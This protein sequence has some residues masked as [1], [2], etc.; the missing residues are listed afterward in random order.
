VVQVVECLPS[1]CEV[2]SS[3]PSTT[4]KENIFIYMYEISIMKPLKLLKGGG[5]GLKNSNIKGEFDQSTKYIICMYIN[6]S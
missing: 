6:I 5:K 3:N 4:K 1:K 2:L